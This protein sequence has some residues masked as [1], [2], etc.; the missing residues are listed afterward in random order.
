MYTSPFKYNQKVV[1]LSMPANPK[2]L[3]TI[4]KIEKDMITAKGD[5]GFQVTTHYS[6][7]KKL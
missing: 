1:Y 6:K 7:F 2:T 5:S 3:L 4:I